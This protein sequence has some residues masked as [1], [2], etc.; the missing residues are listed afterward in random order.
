MNKDLVAYRDH[1]EGARI[2]YAE[3]LSRTR[4]T[5]G[6]TG[7]ARVFAARTARI[8]A[9][10]T[11]VAGA[12]LVAMLG[13]ADKLGHRHPPL[14]VVLL[15][16]WPAMGGA[17]MLGQILGARRAAR[18]SVPAKTEDV[19]GDLARL[20]ADQ[21]L[22]AAR[23]TAARIESVSLALPMIA[24]ALLAPLT[25]HFPVAVLLDA[26]AK[27]DDWIMMSLAIVG[28]A[29]LALAAMYARFAYK[30]RKLD[31]VTLDLDRSA[32]GWGAWCVAVGVSAVPGIVLFVIPPILTA[33]TG[34]VF[35]PLLF[36]A[37][38]RTIIGE[39]Q[40]LA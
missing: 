24:V 28:H 26:G 6:T 14:T 29:H 5:A 38:T 19:L 1:T 7:A 15:A 9:G 3:L 2:R 34:L 11:G 22:E 17:Y 23:H 18:L 37:M 27:F 33:V 35:N 12:A 39:R 31:S 32:F 20:E 25:L 10:T 13:I 21:P 8:W 16:S 36:W 4:N 40:A 30:A